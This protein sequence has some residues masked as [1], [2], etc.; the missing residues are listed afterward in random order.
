VIIQFWD[1]RFLYLGL[2][3]TTLNIELYIYIYMRIFSF[4]GYSRVGLYE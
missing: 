2:L 1:Y 4:K 3:K